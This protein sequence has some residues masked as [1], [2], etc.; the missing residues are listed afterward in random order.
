MFFI[1]NCTVKS[2]FKKILRFL[3]LLEFHPVCETGA[4][5]KDILSITNL[6]S[7]PFFLSIYSIQNCSD[8]NEFCSMILIAD[9][10]YTTVYFLY[11][12]HMN[13]F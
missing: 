13:V 4:L 3:Y 6:L 9:I 12:E 2:R 8:D 10:F 7:S 11:K 1:K 5:E